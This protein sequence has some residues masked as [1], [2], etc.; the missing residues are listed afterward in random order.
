MESSQSDENYLCPVCG[1]DGKDFRGISLHM[2]VVTDIRL[3]CLEY[4]KFKTIEEFKKDLRA[5]VRRRSSQSSAKESSINKVL[6]NFETKVKYGPMFAC[7]CCHTH[8]QYSRVSRIDTVPNLA[9][10]EGR[11][12]FIEP[13]LPSHLFVQ[14]DNMWICNSC[15]NS[16]SSNSLPGLA[17]LNSLQ[18]TWGPSS[19]EFTQ[20]EVDL[21]SLTHMFHVVHSLRC[22]VMRLGGT[23]TLDLYVPL[24]EIFDAEATPEAER[25]PEEVLLQLHIRPPGERPVVDWSRFRQG[26]CALLENSHRYRPRRDDVKQDIL[27]FWD[28]LFAEMPFIQEKETIAEEEEVVQEEDHFTRAGPKVNTMY[29]VVLP[30]SIDELSKGQKKIVQIKNLDVKIGGVLD[31]PEEKAS[32]E[33]DREVTISV[34]RWVQQRMSHVS[35]AGPCSRPGFVFGLLLKETLSKLTSLRPVP[36]QN[37]EVEEDV[38]L[39]TEEQKNFLLALIPGTEKYL[40]LKKEELESRMQWYGPPTIFVTLTLSATTQDV[41]ACF[42]SHSRKEREDFQV[43]HENDEASMLQLRP[44]KTVPKRTIGRQYFLHSKSLT[45][46]DNCPFHTNCRREDLVAGVR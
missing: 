6:E 26:V 5:R 32:M 7:A 13:Q 11:E 21:L 31:D 1:K 17:S 43:W 39:E 16:I 44:G 22:G 24:T 10:R 28:N 38:C 4:T 36:G 41:V 27:N 20:E 9:T 2:Q 33:V 34:G 19:S 37:D 40:E 14:L 42:T 30:V 8:H 25:P 15:K 29:S 35:R 46:Y 18:G 45:R 12:K 3:P 23:T